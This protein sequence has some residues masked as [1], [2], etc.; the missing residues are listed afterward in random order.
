MENKYK[1]MISED[2][3]LEMANRYIQLEQEYQ[4]LKQKYIEKIKENLKLLE[5]ITG[6]KIKS[7]YH[8]VN[9]ERFNKAYV[10]TE[11]E[12]EKLKNKINQLKTK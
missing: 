4:E 9:E 11:N 8:K 12:L 7:D 5:D 6:L 1:E 2:A 3:L 10:S